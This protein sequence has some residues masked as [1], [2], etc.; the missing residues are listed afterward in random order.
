MFSACPSNWL[1]VGV[2]LN[3]ATVSLCFVWFQL[4]RT[5][6][7]TI[8]AKN[9]KRNAPA[10]A[11]LIQV[12]HWSHNAHTAIRHLC[13]KGERNGAQ[14]TAKVSLGRTMI[15]A[16]RLAS[17]DKTTLNSEEIKPVAINQVMLVWRHQLVSRSDGGSVGWTVG[18]LVSQSVEILLNKNF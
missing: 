6:W 18:R 13:G 4:L 16:R 15:P 11:A 5:R 14:R 9:C 3:Y 7:V 1:K 12:L 17:C 8:Q 10:S 2:L